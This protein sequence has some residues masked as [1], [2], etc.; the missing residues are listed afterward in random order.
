M[1][2]RSDIE[3]DFESILEGEFSSRIVFY[4]NGRRVENTWLAQQNGSYVSTYG[5]FDET[6]EEIAQNENSAP[7][8]SQI[9]RVV[10]FDPP[11]LSKGDPVDVYDSGELK[12]YTVFDVQKDSEKNAIVR[13]TKA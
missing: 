3:D 5:I 12:Y 7:V 6:Y 8:V 4:P 13:L 2:F 1:S 11:D 10:V 9:A